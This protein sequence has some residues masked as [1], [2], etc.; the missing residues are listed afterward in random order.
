[1]GHVAA[2]AIRCGTFNRIQA[3]ATL[4][5][6]SCVLVQHYRLLHTIE[7]LEEKQ[8]ALL[9]LLI[10]LVK[11]A[12]PVQSGQQLVHPLSQLAGILGSSTFPCSCFAAVHVDTQTSMSCR[13]LVGTQP[14]DR[15]AVLTG[16]QARRPVAWLLLRP[17]R[18]HQRG[19]LQASPSVACLSLCLHM[20]CFVT[21]FVTVATAMHS[22]CCQALIS[23]A[24]LSP[25]CLQLMT[26]KHGQKCIDDDTTETVVRPAAVF[27]LTTDYGG[28][29]C[30]TS[31]G[32]LLRL[33]QVLTPYG[34]VAGVSAA[35]QLRCLHARL[36]CEGRRL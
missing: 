12:L 23:F 4:A 24:W 25:V 14:E 15:E 20:A 17:P 3:C 2:C 13:S 7:K 10:L 32:M 5:V 36:H 29:P 21:C 34:A 33:E 16:L 35:H 1:M 31:H 18:T 22:A 28:Q 27:C 19:P 9:A 11:I 6:D 30:V 26:T 8:D